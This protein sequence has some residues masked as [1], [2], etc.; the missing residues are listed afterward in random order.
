MMANYKYLIKNIGILVLGNFT[1][2]LL[3]FFL[4]PLYTASL[5][6]TEYGSFDLIN[7]TI[8]LIIPIF[9][10]N[11]LEGIFRYSLDKEVNKVNLINIGFKY[12]FISFIPLLIL[13]FINYIFNLIPVFNEY[14]WYFLLMYFSMALSG[15]LTSI[16][17]GFEKLSAIAVSG[18]ISSIVVIA[19]NIYFLLIVKWGLDGYFVASI[20]GTS[21]QCIYIIIDVK[22]WK[23]IKKSKNNFDKQKILEK[24][25]LNYSKPLIA[26]SVSWWINNVSDRYIVT[27]FCGFAINGIYSIAYKI[28]TFLN[29]IVSI[30]NQAWNLSAIKDFN[31]NDE[32]GFF[33]KTYS[34]YNCLMALICSLMIVFDKIISKILFANDFYIAWKYV[35]FLLIAFFFG[36]LSGYLGGIFAAV[37]RSDI[38]AKSTIIGA[39]MNVL[40]NFL[41]VYKIGALG[42]AIATTISYF[43][44]WKIRFDEIKKFIHI[45]INIRRDLVIYLILLIQAILLLIINNNFHLYILE[46]IC[47]FIISV[48]LRKDIINLTQFLLKKLGGKR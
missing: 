42:A 23:Y 20:L 46:I 37:K 34:I 24:K 9:T 43:V 21:S 39:I 40:L 19:S 41:L 38:Y 28:P 16:A 44:V 35:P 32:N 11:I 30:F 47:L 29:L 17:K 3:S 12:F 18:V 22:I 8:G 7:T 45:K 27:Y 15:I 14:L 48:L 1:T 31:Q 33:S 13:I 6:T 2:K 36:A 4:I 25:V 10:F 26:N 5:T